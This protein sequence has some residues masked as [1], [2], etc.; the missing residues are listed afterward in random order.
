MNFE[1]MF[2]LILILLFLAG[3]AVPASAQPVLSLSYQTIPETPMP[4][5]VFALQINIVNSGYAVKDVRLTVS[6]REE[7]L[8]IIS[9][10]NRLSYLT[11]N[12]GELTGSASTAIKLKADREGT[13]QLKV[14]LSYNYGGESLEE[15]IPIVVLEK[16]SLIIEKISQPVL[17]P[18][19]SGKAVLEVTNTGGNAK[20]VEIL[21]VTPDG[22]VAK[23]SR[24]SFDEWNSGE[25]K[26]IVFNISASKEVQTGVYP[27][28]LVF[29]YADRL[30]NAYQE[31]S[32]F[33]I[34]VEGQPEITF[35][36]FKTNPE[37][38]Y[39]DDDFVLSLT[40]ENTGKDDAK[41]VVLSLS[42]PDKFSGENEA[43]VGT[44]K[45]GERA[46]VSFKLKADRKAESGNYPFRLTVRYM[47]NGKIKEKNFDFSLFIDALGSINLDISGL[48]F[49]PKKVAPS[50]DFTLSLQI[51]NAGKQDAKAVAVKLILPEG[52]EGK[53][54]YFI[55]TLESGDSA[56]STFDL[57]APDKAGEY[58][59]KA[60]IT[61]M[62]SAFEK[63]SVEKEF[64]VY[65]FPEASNTTGF[66]ALAIVAV[67]VAGGYLWRRK[68]K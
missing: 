19:S 1:R 11:V 33:A 21:L 42:Y 7:N 59:V 46:E 10:E 41:N 53:N 44:L 17:Q 57:I 23:T 26:T 36:G 5:D 16:P 67:L 28:K 50:S 25:K 13:Y 20:N 27:A 18:D 2:F 62:D 15:V 34:N 66:I 45:R 60:V 24:M 37:R 8:A 3:S 9:G 68:A 14:K 31:E 56:T 65:I 61:Y 54:Q 55:G 39:P 29:N 47:D 12:I 38:I 48:Y 40:V 35:S 43:F 52:F 22:F 6:E 63:Y 32:Q 51:E 49:S 4:R 64:S 30:G 58:R